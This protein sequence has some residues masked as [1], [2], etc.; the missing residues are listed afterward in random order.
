MEK[1]IKQLVTC[2]K[3]EYALF[4]ALLLLLVT[5]YEFEVLQEGALIDEPQTEYMVKAAGILLAVTLIPLSLRLFSLSM[6]QSVQHRPLQEAL[7][8]YRRWCEIRLGLLLVP[9]LIN[10]SVYYW[11]LDNTG[12]LCAA[13]VLMASFFCVPGEKRLR[14]ELNLDTDEKEEP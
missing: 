2:L 12:L 6:V 1:Q 3:I 8:S 13:M 7:V 10:L 9:A 14:M 11:T 5:L 4:W